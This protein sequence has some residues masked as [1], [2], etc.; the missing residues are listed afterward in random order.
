MPS[1][2]REVRIVYYLVFITNMLRL[3]MKNNQQATHNHKRV[4]PVVLLQSTTELAKVLVLASEDEF[5]VKRS[6]LTLVGDDLIEKGTTAKI[7][8][9]KT[10]PN[11]SSNP[12]YRVVRAA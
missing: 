9:S 12:Q 6:D 3:S 5:W 4:G 1:R 11:V 7:R 10:R 2:D 8:Q